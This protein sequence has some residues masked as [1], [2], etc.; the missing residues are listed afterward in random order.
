M[1]SAQRTRTRAKRPGKKVVLYVPDTFN[2]EVHLPEDL[3][4]LADYA[5]YLLH[6]INV[7]RVHLRRGH[8]LVYLKHDYLAR[9][10]PRGRLTTIRGALE[11]AGV[12]AVRKFCVPGELCYGYRLRPP[13]DRGF[14]H[15]RPTTKR[16]V[17]R[18][19]AWRARESRE[20]RLPLHRELRRFVKAITIDEQAALGA[21]QG[22]AFERSAQ[23]AMI[24]R[25]A[26]GDF[27]TVVDRFGRF[28][29]NL[30]NL[31]ATLRPF[32]RYR[33]SP[34][35]NLDIANSQPM[36]FC[37]LIINL[38]S[39]DG[40]LDNLIDC[41]FPGTSQ[42]HHI[43]IDQDFLNSLS[44]WYPQDYQEGKNQ[45][46]C[47]NSPVLHAN[48]QTTDYNMMPNNNSQQ[49]N[50]R[51]T[52]SSEHN[53]EEEGEGGT[54][55]SPILHANNQDT[56]YNMMPNN[57]LQQVNNRQTSLSEADNQEGGSRTSTMLHANN[58]SI[59]CNM[60]QDNN[61][62]WVN[63]QRTLS[64]QDTREEEGE[65]GT[66]NSPILHAIRLENEYNSNHNNQLGR[67]S[68]RQ[69]LPQ[70]VLEF[71]DLCERGILYDDLMRRLGV[72]PHRRKA[73][74]RLVFAQV[75]FGRN[76]QTGRLRDLFAGDFPTV[77]QVINDLKRKDYRQLA[78]LLQAHES[79]L[80][81]DIICRRILEEWPG[82][83]VGTI[84]DSILTTPEKAVEVRAIMVREFHKFGLR[85]TIR[86]EAY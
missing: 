53:K 11:N 40:E 37:L 13:H 68:N 43:D 16:L 6:R 19:M 32:L 4:H 9:F 52:V 74:K 45:E 51:Q 85:P 69:A 84:H 2:P 60:R 34:L 26:D 73:F 54:R 25:I 36:I 39:N 66:R 82:T 17:A 65:G 57:N 30:T 62:Q 50:N 83:F 76:Q 67:F 72:P 58:H 5:R 28:H 47:I 31:K 29:T 10:M 48:N 41:S 61:L 80:M 44:Y 18:I 35:V 14:S 81:I 27:S 77:Y 86:T 59:E 38:L 64:S 20:V 15:Y 63:N 49:V 23:I 55:D 70:D 22:N 71:I 1:P 7:G 24:R 46:K 42:P 78:Y 75:F 21:V 3:R 12:I 79:K 8:A 56:E 33:G